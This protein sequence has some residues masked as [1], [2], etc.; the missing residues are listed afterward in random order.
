LSEFED[1]VESIEKRVVKEYKS[2]LSRSCD[3]EISQGKH[4]G[5][6]GGME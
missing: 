6:F 4:G 1:Q 3:E 5:E 2:F